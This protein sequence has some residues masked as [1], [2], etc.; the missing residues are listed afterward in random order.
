M[1]FRV[2]TGADT[3]LL[4]LDLYH[5]LNPNA[6]AKSLHKDPSVHLFAYNV[7][8]I[9]Y[10]GIYLLQVHF[11]CNCFVVNFYAVG[12]GKLILCL[13]YSRKCGL[14]SV[15]CAVE[16]STNFGKAQPAYHDKDQT[17]L[18]LPSRSDS[19]HPKQNMH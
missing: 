5:K 19:I 13:E 6:T 11:K 18:P 2:D 9:Q 12:K 1:Q 4:P 8:E 7:S 10:F 3:N 14:F 15:Y 17:T 16:K